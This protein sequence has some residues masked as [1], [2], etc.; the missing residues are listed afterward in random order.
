[1]AAVVSIHEILQDSTTFPDI[2]LLAIL[3]HVGE[4]RNT[5]I[6]VDVEVPLF[7]LLVLEELDRAYLEANVR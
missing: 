2:Q 7:F 5:A 1:M 4:G 6:W 3:I